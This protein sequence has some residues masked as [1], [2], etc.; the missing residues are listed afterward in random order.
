M[1]ALVAGTAHSSLLLLEA[2]FVEQAAVGFAVL[3]LGG[4]SLISV[5]H[6]VPVLVLGLMIAPCALLAWQLWWRQ[7]LQLWGGSKDN[8]DD[9]VSTSFNKQKTE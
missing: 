8:D 2:W 9:V 4:Q 1:W 6:A 7:A 5:S 3:G